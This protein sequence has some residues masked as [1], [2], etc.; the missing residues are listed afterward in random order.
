L[1][2][3]I[4]N[5]IRD[6]ARDGV[7]FCLAWFVPAWL[8][9]ELVPTKL[10]HYPLPLYPALALLVSTALWAP[11]EGRKYRT[12][13]V[14]WAIAWTI[15]G[16]VL[17][18]LVG[19]ATM[20]YGAGLVTALLIPAAFALIPLLATIRGLRRGAFRQSVLP[21]VSVSAVV[22]PS[23]FA[24]TMPRLQDLWIAQRAEQV[25]N[26]VST[27]NRP[28]V[29]VAGFTEP[30][31]VFALGTDT[32]LCDGTGAAT[33]LEQYPAAIVIVDDDAEPGFLAACTGNQ[34]PVAPFGPPTLRGFNYTK[35]R[36]LNLHFYHR[37]DAPLPYKA[38]V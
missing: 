29:A 32:V 17:A 8:V 33:H 23:L 36:W 34:I 11:A 25:V 26:S 20:Q 5:A 3:G 1:G 24:L 14:L 7:R 13:F 30:S 9:L 18:G 2:S 35:G 37:I 31:I 12:L 19:G 27:N 10:P 4:V 6:R 16:L 28:P 38:P 15:T 21:A 22:L